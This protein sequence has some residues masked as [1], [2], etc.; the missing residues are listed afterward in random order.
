MGNRRTVNIFSIFTILRE[1]QTDLDRQR[2]TEPEI[3]RDRERKGVGEGGGGGRYNTR[4]VWKVC[5][6][7]KDS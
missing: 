7:C 5:G 3:E 4:E 2:E 6:G 1:R